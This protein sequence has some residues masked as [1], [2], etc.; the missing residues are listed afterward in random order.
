M[1]AAYSVLLLA[2]CAPSAIPPSPPPIL[3]APASVVD[4]SLDGK[5]FRPQSCSAGTAAGFL[6]FELTGE[7]GA[8]LRITSELDGSSKVVVFHP[9]VDRG[10]VLLDCARAEMKESRG[11]RSSTV[12]GRAS[13]RCEGQGVRV[14]GTVLYDH[15]QER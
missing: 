13:L 5:P 2:A 12:H 14:E 15:C 4:L 1:R 3:Q 10:I 6:G 7:D 8:R 11:R 9:G